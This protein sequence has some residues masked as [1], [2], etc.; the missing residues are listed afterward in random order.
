M[1]DLLA[2]LISSQ[3]SR[4]LKNIGLA[5]AAGAWVH[6]W[7]KSGF[8]IAGVTPAVRGSSGTLC[9]K[10]TV[11]ALPLV[12]AAGGLN[13]YIAR[14]LAS[15]LFAGSLSIVD[16]LWQVSGFSGTDIAEQSVTTPPT[17]TRYAD[18]VGVELWCVIW[19]I[20]GST[21]TTFTV[22]YT[23]EAGNP[24]IVTPATTFVLGASAAPTV[25]ECFPV[26]LTTK[27]IRKVQSADLLAT[28]GTAGDFGFCLL[29]R[30]VTIPVPNI[31]AANL[32]DAFGCGL[33]EVLDNAC[34]G[35]I[36]QPNVTTSSFM[37]GEI[38]IVEG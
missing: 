10:D 12:N 36:W 20:T 6:G 21:V 27:G 28:T 33:P 32:L 2:A 3:K 23:D 24:D 26:P 37:M 16:I 5:D 25:D 9:S 1:D 7:R 22:K 8:P 29:R 35:F 11:G 13:L 31:G 17:L 4:F 14:A 19:T 15:G 34:L 30:L 18:G 38:D